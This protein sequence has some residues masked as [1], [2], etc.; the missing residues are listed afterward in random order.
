MSEEISRKLT[1]G[2]PQ[3]IDITWVYGSGKEEQ[4]EKKHM[5]QRSV[6]K[7]P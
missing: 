3:F 1:F 6:R 7:G 4:L 2:M 5:K